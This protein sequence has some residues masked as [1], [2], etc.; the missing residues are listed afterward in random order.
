MP[1]PP[2]PRPPPPIR[3]LVFHLIHQL[4]PQFIAIPLILLILFRQLQEAIDA[5]LPQHGWLLRAGVGALAWCWCGTREAER[6]FVF[7]RV[8]KSGGWA[9]LLGMTLLGFAT[10]LRRGLGAGAGWR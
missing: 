1:D 3:H 5:H 4:L 2:L 7:G 10:G 8:S 9:A 6:Y